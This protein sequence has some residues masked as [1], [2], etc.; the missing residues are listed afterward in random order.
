MMTVIVFIAILGLLVLVHEFGHFIL[1]RRNGVKVDEFGFGL[2]PRMFGVYLGSDGKWKLVG[3]KIREAE[4]TIYSFNWLPLGGFVRM[5]GEEET[6]GPRLVE[7]DSFASKS[8]GARL[9]IISAGVSMNL[10]LA[11]VL[12]TIGFAVGSPQFIDETVPADARVRDQVIRV[13]EVLPDSPASSAGLQIGDTILEVDGQRVIAVTEF[14]EYITAHQAESITFLIE[15][16][17]QRQEQSL[18]PAALPGLENP[19][20]GIALVSTGTLS[21]PIYTAWW[22]ALVATGKMIVG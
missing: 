13:L 3:S 9:R 22:H 10:L 5:K 6:E 17:G 21:Y 2:P 16:D 11:I 4:R 7:S 14:Q 1:A 12:L 15:R 18:T 8:I 19:G 20:I